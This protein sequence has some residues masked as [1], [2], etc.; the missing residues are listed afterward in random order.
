MRESSCARHSAGCR[1]AQSAKLRVASLYL[2]WPA[3]RVVPT[4]I[5]PERCRRSRC[6]SC[7][8][9]S[10][11]STPPASEWKIGEATIRAEAVTHRGPTLGFRITDGD[12]RSLHLRPRA[13]ARRAAGRPRARVD[14]RLQP[15]PRRRPADPRLP[16]HR[17]GVPRPRGMGPLARPTRSPSPSGSAP[18]APCSSTTTPSTPTASSTTWRDARSGRGAGLGRGPPS[19]RSAR[20]AASSRSSPAV[21]AR[22]RLSV[23]GPS[24]QPVQGPGQI[25][26]AVQTPRR[27]STTHCCGSVQPRPRAMLGRQ[28]GKSDDQAARLWRRLA[29]AATLVVPGIASAQGVGAVKGSS[30]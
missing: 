13:G 21:Q 11:S 7:P 3:S 30:I 28:G 16:V 26:T 10:P 24:R 29:L 8:A 15:R 25:W 9:T 23:G 20:S 27:R 2:N 5:D 6:A 22:P 1:Q 18:S 19:S 14:L 12:G 4:P 17:R